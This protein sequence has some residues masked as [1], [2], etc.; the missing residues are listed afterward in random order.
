M[1]SSANALRPEV[2]CLRIPTE[3]VS[4]GDSFL[5]KVTRQVD[6]GHDSDVI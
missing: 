3:T 4:Q 6:E 2:P 1:N 5:D